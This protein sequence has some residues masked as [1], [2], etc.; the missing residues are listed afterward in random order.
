MNHPKHE[1]TLVIIKPDG[2]QRSLIGEVVQ[3]FER[4]GLKLA[5]LKFVVADE[6]LIENHYT[7]EDSWKENVGKK[8]IASYKALMICCR[9]H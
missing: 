9:Q 6:E 5:A 4:V 3:R 7:V 8:T 2:I 1:R